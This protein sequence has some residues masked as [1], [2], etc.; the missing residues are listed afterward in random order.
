[1]DELELLLDLHRNTARQGPGGVA[2]TQLAISLSGLRD[3]AN[4]KIADIGCGSGASTL[5][6]AEALDAHVTAIDF[7]P[8]FLTQLDEEAEKKG[9]SERIDAL[10]IRM[11][12]LHFDEGSLDAIWSEGAIYNIGFLNGIKAWRRFLKP[13]GVL[14]VSELTWLTEKRPEELSRH[15]DAEYPE[16]ATAS[17]KIRQLEGNGYMLLGYFPLPKSNWMDNFYRPLQARFDAYLSRHESMDAAKEIVAATQRE[18]DLY[19]RFSDY[20]SYGYYIARKCGD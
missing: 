19:E 14:A 20:V 12:D 11:E 1:M 5:V 6:I 2:E 10:T 4:L 15:W 7:L 17:Q 13:N 9:L 16:V 3:A 18:I 8:D